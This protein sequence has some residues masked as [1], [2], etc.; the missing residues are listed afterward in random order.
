[1]N[2][3]QGGFFSKASDFAKKNL[4]KVVEEAKEAYPDALEMTKST[5]SNLSEKM[6]EV[7]SKAGDAL[8]DVA[9]ST[10]DK[11]TEAKEAS[12]ELASSAR[13]KFTE[14]IDT[15]R[16]RLEEFID[17]KK[18]PRL[19]LA[20]SSI[21]DEERLAFYGVIFCVASANGSM[22]QDGL[23][24]ILENMT[25]DTFSEVVRKEIHGYILLQPS[26]K[27]SLRSLEESEESIR[28]GLMVHLVKLA[29]ASGT[30]DEDSKNALLKAEKKLGVSE[31]QR[32]AIDKYVLETKR[33]QEQ[34]LDDQAAADVVKT[35]LSG[36]TDA[37]IPLAAR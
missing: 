11:F 29:Q 20:H 30:V 3:K 33:I 36:L 37:G 25:I 34:E 31:I 18:N 26:F 6:T 1:M 15:T 13:D 21:S 10:K 2:D 14:A 27:K 22:N 4:N 19:N 16:D 7:G 23:H 8:S 32:T 17:E 9:D 35:V 28:F 5:V 24:F 12:S